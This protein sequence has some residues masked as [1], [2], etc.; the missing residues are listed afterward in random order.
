V[1][2][3]RDAER[4]RAR[5]IEAAREV[6]AERGFAATLDDIARHAGLGTGTAYRHFA[7]KHQLAALV[8]AESNAALLADVEAANRV[9]DP[10]PALVGLCEAIAARQAG[11]RGLHEALTGAARGEL[12]AQVWPQITAGVTAL[13]ERA[14]RAGVVRP[15]LAPTDIGIVLG[16]LGPVYEFGE[17]TR[18]PD[19]WRRYLAMVLDGLRATDASP[20]PEPALTEDELNVMIFGSAGESEPSPSA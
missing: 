9:E 6:F 8:V 15:D 11:N 14:Q 12:K 20:A 3:R 17:R 19:L 10:W 18:H 5:L 4:N 13:V 16:M 1:S 2:P 7:D